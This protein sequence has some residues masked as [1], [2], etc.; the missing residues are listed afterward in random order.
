[1]RDGRV[2]MREQRVGERHPRGAGADDEIVGFELVVHHFI[3][4]WSRRSYFS[5]IA[6]FL[7]LRAARHP[8]GRVLLPSVVS[9]RLLRGRRLS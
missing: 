1:M 4:S 7:V 5:Y 3:A 2:G 9:Q 6:G 8:C